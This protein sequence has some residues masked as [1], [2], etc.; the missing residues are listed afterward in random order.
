MKEVG[1]AYASRFE[2]ISEYGRDIILRYDTIPVTWAIFG[3]ERHAFTISKI[4]GKTI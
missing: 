3:I 4:K 1:M 2:A